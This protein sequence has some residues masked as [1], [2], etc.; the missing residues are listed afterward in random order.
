M[1]FG[2]PESANDPTTIPDFSTPNV[3][4]VASAGDGSVPADYPGFLPN[5]VA[6][7]GTSLTLNGSGYGGEV[8]WS[9]G[10]GGQSSYETE[11]SFQNA[12]QTSGFRQ[13]PDVSWD[14][15]PNTGVNVYDSYNG[16]Y[17]TGS[18]YVYGGT[19]LGAPSWA[20]LIAIA[21]QL[22]ASKSLGPLTS[23]TALKTLYSLPVADFHDI[24]GGNNGISAA[25]GYDQAT[26][27]GTPIANKLVPDL[28]LGNA[29]SPT[30][31]GTSPSLAGG[32]LTLG[33][34][35]LTITFS[36][37]V[38]G[39][40][41]A[42]N[43]ELIS[44][45][46]DGLLGTA[47]DV[48]IPLSV[49]WTGST[50]TLSFAP[51]A[52]NVYRLTILGTL[53]NASGAE[54]A[55]NGTAG[56]NWVT[57]FAVVPNIS[58]F[59]SAAS[60]STDTGGS[61]NA[62][63]P[64]SVAVGDFN[65]DGKPDLAVA[66]SGTNTVMIL[67]NQGNGTFTVGNS[68]STGYVHYSHSGSYSAVPYGI[69]A[70]DFN[71]DGK[72]DLAIA[73]YDQTNDTGTIQVYLGNGDGTF[74]ADVTYTSSNIPN[75]SP[76]SIL[77]GD[78]NGDGKLDLAVA[79]YNNGTVTVLT[80]KGDGTFP[81]YASYNSGGN[82][83]R[84]LAAADFN[85]DGKLDLAVANYDNGTVGVLLNNGSGASP[86]RPRTARAAPIREVWRW[87]T[88]MATASPIWPWPTTPPARSAFC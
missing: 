28:A 52:G 29:P 76:I 82:S 1:S 45:G 37:P 54:L 58:L 62:S 34:A 27:L 38:V 88:S 75:I 47:D 17:N 55:G 31:V 48:T 46:P 32:A 81:T 43:Y 40:G 30:V 59:G 10:G 22:R 44:S 65:G 73:N 39:G 74:K 70:G 71:G 35:S 69:V 25:A 64:L 83:P 50:A 51:L 23:S 63:D 4:F 33:A 7:G 11:P 15:D 80:G 36:E 86:P 85:G 5:V 57:D 19:S 56:S 14:A 9:S 21:D 79:N 68:Y 12:V 3:T 26:G 20:G 49:S 53:A 78:F 42:S 87:A 41:A 67:I 77:A 61:S 8:A 84:A 60:Y 18:W 2:F 6:V 24:N 13:A 66:N 72:L 16:P